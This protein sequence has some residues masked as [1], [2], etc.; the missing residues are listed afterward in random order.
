[1]PF[2]A[3]CTFLLALQIS[4]G[5]TFME[6]NSE[7]KKNSKPHGSLSFFFFFFFGHFF[8]IRF[9]IQ[10]DRDFFY[11]CSNM[12]FVKWVDFLGVIFS[13]GSL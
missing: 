5:S 11:Y 4:I 10:D 9:E 3:N 2:H 8:S 13:C 6:P 12:S 7:K 1:M